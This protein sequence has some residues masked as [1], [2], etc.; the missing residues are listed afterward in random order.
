MST[1]SNTAILLDIVSRLGGI[2]ATLKNIERL[3]LKLEKVESRLALVT[4]RT[5]HLE[6]FEGRVASYIWLGGAIVSGVLFFLWE[7]IKYIF[8]AGDLIRRFFHA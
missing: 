2:E 6:T 3:E 4:D 5:E 1:E 8:P 7:G